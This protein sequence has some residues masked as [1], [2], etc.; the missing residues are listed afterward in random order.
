[1][2]IKSFCTLSKDIFASNICEL[3]LPYRLTFSVTDRCQARCTMCNIWKKPIANELS[4]EEINQFFSSANHFSWINLTGGELFQRQDIQEIFKIIVSHN[5][6]LHLLNF[7]TN[8]ILT[9][10]IIAAVDMLLKKST[11]PRLIVSVSMDGPPDVHDTIRGYPG[12]WNHAIR[13]FNELRKYSSKRFAVYFGHTIQSANLGIFDE[14]LAQCNNAI[15]NVTVNDF[16]L[17]LAHQSGHYYDNSDSTAIPNLD[18]ATKEFRRIVQ[19]RKQKILDPVA[20]IEK[21][22]QQNTAQYLTTGRVSIPCVAGAAS[23]FITPQGVVHPCSVF[24]SAIGSL[25]DYDMNFNLLWRSESRISVR[26]TI[27]KNS[28]PGC[29]TPCEAYQTLLANLAHI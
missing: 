10:E 27:I 28:C 22:Y 20:F 5:K 11:L 23:C 3:Q 16:H 15:G 6:N 29:W 8:A 17:N 14:T 2:S 19:Q 24:D 26:N 12:C 4:L 1:M 13:T 9:D 25:R 21:R 7:P 18:Q